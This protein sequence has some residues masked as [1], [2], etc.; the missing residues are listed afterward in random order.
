MVILLTADIERFKEIEEVHWEYY[1]ELEKDMLSTRRYVDFDKA[2]TS[3]FSL[4]YL[5][6]LQAVC[7]EIDIVGKIIAKELNPDFRPD[8]RKNSIL[9]WW[10]EIQ[11]WYDSIDEK[12]VLFCRRIEIEPW[13]Q[14]RVE[15]YR[16]KRNAIGYRIAN[17]SCNNT[18]TWWTSYNSVKHCRTI[19]NKR[20]DM[21]YVK[22]NLGNLSK[23]FAGLYV[24]EK[25]YLYGLGDK[26][27]IARLEKS[28]LF[29]L[30][31]TTE[32]KV[33]MQVLVP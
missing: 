20:G 32:I 1:L 19:R 29:D 25:N 31:K 9:K 7:S 21:N 27:N 6:L 4:E 16:N 8:D 11:D 23:A 2:N 26:K 17:R 14:F 12:T 5:K 18:P 28:R 24:L 13:R 3:T 10:Y 33:G 15:K 30:R 22:A